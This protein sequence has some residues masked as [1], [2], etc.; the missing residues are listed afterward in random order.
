[1]S[2]CVLMVC[3]LPVPPL[4]PQVLPKTWGLSL[5]SLTALALNRQ[6]TPWGL[7]LVKQELLHEVHKYVVKEYVTQIIKPR[8]KM[9]RET[10]QQ[11]SRKMS[12]EAAIIHSAL[13]DQVRELS[14]GIPWL[15]HSQRCNFPA[16][17]HRDQAAGS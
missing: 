2:E 7:L 16:W 10:R 3:C 9:N 12:L 4:C 17:L 14:P 15:P 13:I 6:K 11:A 8:W 1:M 5:T